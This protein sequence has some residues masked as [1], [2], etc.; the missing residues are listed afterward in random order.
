M[1]SVHSLEKVLTTAA[2]HA[3][4]SVLV[5]ASNVAESILLN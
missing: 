2:D 3:P 4:V 1:L 5:M